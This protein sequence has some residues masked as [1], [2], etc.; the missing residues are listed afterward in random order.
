M[1]GQW[2]A[3]G[4]CQQFYSSVKFCLQSLLTAQNSGMNSQLCSNF[5][6]APYILGN[7]KAASTFR[8]SAPVTELSF[9]PELIKYQRINRIIFYTNRPSLLWRPSHCCSVNNLKIYMLNSI[10]ECTLPSS[11]YWGSLNSDIIYIYIY[12]VIFSLFFAISAGVNL[13]LF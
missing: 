1:F 6:D 12:L 8:T 5:L 9:L 4:F 10:K 3:R 2:Y 7:Y 13:P 11:A